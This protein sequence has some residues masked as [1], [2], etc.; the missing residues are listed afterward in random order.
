M[1]TLKWLDGTSATTI[2]D[3]GLNSLANNAGALSAAL[4]NDTD[5]AYLADIEVY[6]AGFGAS[7]NKGTAYVEVYL[8]PTVDGTNYPDTDSNVPQ[9]TYF[10]GSLLKGTANGSGAVRDVL[11]EVP[12]PARD[13]KIAVVNKSGQAWS[14]SGNTVKIRPVRSQAV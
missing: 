7:I 13:F 6:V 10:I 4:D 1:S 3:T 2:L 14:A 9:P 11:R 5:L 8:L 12:L